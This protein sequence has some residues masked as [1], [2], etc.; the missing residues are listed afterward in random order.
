MKKTFVALLISFQ[1][2]AGIIINPGGGSSLPDQTGN[3]GKF[4][5]TNGT[6]ASWATVTAGD[7]SGPASSTANAFATFSGTG[8]KTLQSTSTM[9]LNPTTGVI[10]YAPAASGSLFLYNMANVTAASNGL[11]FTGTIGGSAGAYYATRSDYVIPSGSAFGAAHRVSVSGTMSTTDYY[12]GFYTN[13][14][15]VSTGNRLGAVSQIPFASVGYAAF[16]NNGG[17]SGA[18]IGTNMGV[19]S[20]NRNVGGFYSAAGGGGATPRNLAVVGIADLQTSATGV[21]GWF[22]LDTTLDTTVENANP[23]QSAALIADNGDTTAD[24]FVTMDAGVV[25]FEVADGGA[26]TLGA[27]STTPTHRFNSATVAAGTDLMTLENGPANT[28]GDPD[29]FLSLDING[30]VHVIPAWTP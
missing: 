11:F 23:G 16:L 9:T 3:S 25:S 13:Q 20:A 30:T 26:V 10:S 18:Q 19:T 2:M 4:L 14:S 7:V 8:G 28:A 17:T 27:A 6:V 15:T 21:G 22:R 5:T 24:S 1:A 12:A 29:T